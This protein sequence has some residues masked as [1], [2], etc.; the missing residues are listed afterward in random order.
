MTGVLPARARIILAGCLPL[1][2]C[3]Q[4]SIHDGDF[5]CGAMPP[6]CPPQQACGGD[7]YCHSG[8]VDPAP[9]S[10]IVP[11]G[12]Y[13]L[14]I[15]GTEGHYLRT[16]IDH[17][18]TVQVG[19]DHVG[20][21]EAWILVVATPATVA[22]RCKY[23]GLYVTA[24]VSSPRAPLSSDATTIGKAQ[25]FQLF[26]RSDG[27]MGI[28][29]VAAGYDVATDPTVNGDAFADREGPA[30]AQGFTLVAQK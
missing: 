23:N 2:G 7:G 5:L 29:S 15:S 4:I 1:L 6:Y 11:S 24:D 25:Q 12:A 14:L 10:P 9:P 18:T 20:N 8:T 28:F 21:Y 19:W 27:T 30:A 13:A 26:D 22:L 3:G 17:G 16:D